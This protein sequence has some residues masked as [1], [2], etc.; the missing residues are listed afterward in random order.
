MHLIRCGRGGK[1][2]QSRNLMATMVSAFVFVCRSSW[3][4]YSSSS[5]FVCGSQHIEV[6]LLQRVFTHEWQRTE[7]NS[8]VGTQRREGIEGT[9]SRPKEYTTEWE[10]KLFIPD[11]KNGGQ[12]P[13]TLVHLPL[14]R[15][16]FNKSI[17]NQLQLWL[18]NEWITKLFVFYLIGNPWISAS[19]WMWA[20]RPLGVIAEG[21]SPLC[22]WGEKTLGQFVLRIR[23]RWHV[24]L[25]WIFL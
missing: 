6:T 15:S 16:P 11:N 12:L 1:G 25:C 4:I 22:G 13:K 19:V 24:C 10:K 14:H 9:I 23:S 21:V 18:D 5:G 2:G 3:K 8:F 20:D 17:N 7:M